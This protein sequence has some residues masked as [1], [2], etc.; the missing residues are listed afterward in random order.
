MSSLNV[1]SFTGRAGRDPEIRHL[2][3]GVAVTTT[4]VAVNQRQRK[5][6]EQPPLWIEVAMWGKRA[7]GI[8]DYVRKGDLL[9]ISGELQ[10]PDPWVD[11]QGNARARLKV[12]ASDIQFLHSPNRE[13]GQQP[14]PAAAPTQASSW[15]TSSRSGGWEDSTNEIPF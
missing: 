3:G 7:Q 15:N 2:D 5:G 9:A 10:P 14:A 6:E 13:Q 1:F 11:Q 4:L 12:N 8:A